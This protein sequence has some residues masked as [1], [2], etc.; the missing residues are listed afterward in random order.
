MK[1]ADAP[2]TI[3]DE[4]DLVLITMMAIIVLSGNSNKN[5]TAKMP[6]NAPTLI[7]D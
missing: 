6:R 1:A 3:D 7:E 4:R 5:I 2:I